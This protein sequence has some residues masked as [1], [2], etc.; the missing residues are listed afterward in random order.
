MV[1]WGQTILVQFG[2]KIIFFVFEYVSDSRGFLK[3]F[4][5]FGN[6]PKTAGVRDFSRKP[7]KFSQD[8]Q[9][10]S[11]NSCFLIFCPNWSWSDDSYLHLALS[12]LKRKK[13]NKWLK[14]DLVLRDVYL[15]KWILKITL[16]LKQDLFDGDLKKEFYRNW[17]AR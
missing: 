2:K 8:H 6:H 14:S 16:K 17:T 13:I 3:S 15:R 9:W 7:R 5:K 4:W 11:V 1:T 10:T 12:I